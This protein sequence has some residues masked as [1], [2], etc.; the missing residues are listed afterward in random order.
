MTGGR[1]GHRGKTKPWGQPPQ[2]PIQARIGVIG[3]LRLV[4]TTPYEFYG[5]AGRD[6]IF[7]ATSLGLRSFTQ[8]AA[9]DAFEEIDDAL[10]LLRL[11]AVD[12][13]MLNGIPML[14]NLEPNQISTFRERAGAFAPR[15]GWTAVDACVASIKA[16]GATRVA[17][18]SKW[19]DDLNAKLASV[20]AS[21]EIAV[22]GSVGRSDDMAEIQ[23]DYAKGSVAAWDLAHAARVQYPSADMIFLAGAAWLT[24]HL[25]DDL[26]KEVGMPV[27]TGLQSTNWFAL[28]MVDAFEP[29]Q[30]QGSLLRELVD[31]EDL[32][33][34]TGSVP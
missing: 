5:V 26:E 14:V 7:T 11:R 12:V 4:D 8:Q 15:G 29:R 34:E 17:I 18:A 1:P 25:L 33:L 31:F 19:S 23:G 9:Q 2:L 10:D 24:L 22:V 21:K 28:N 30:G 27:V 16:I 3:P 6:V 20:L 32:M 13:V